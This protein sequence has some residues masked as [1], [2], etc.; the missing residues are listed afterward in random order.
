MVGKWAD[1][2]GDQEGAEDQ[3]EDECAGRRRSQV[4]VEGRAAFSD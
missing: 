3:L 4:G 2:D 1:Q